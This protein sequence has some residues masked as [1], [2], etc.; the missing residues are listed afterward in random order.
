VEPPVAAAASLVPIVALTLA[1]MAIGN[2]RFSNAE[3]IHGSGLAQG[4][5]R[6]KTL[7]A[8]HQNTLDQASLVIAVY[9]A[10]D[11]RASALAVTCPTRCGRPCRWRVR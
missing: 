5:A 4:S 2:C 10:V 7:R 3:D 1:V 11:E 9:F 8:I 6:I